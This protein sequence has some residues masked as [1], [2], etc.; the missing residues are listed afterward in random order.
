MGCP[1]G[2]GPMTSSQYFWVC[3]TCGKTVS[4]V[5]PPLPPPLA[6]LLPRLP[7]VL[8]VP[9]DE[10]ARE[11]VPYV[12]LHW[13]RVAAEMLPRFCTAVLLGVL[14]SWN[15]GGEFPK[16]VHR[17]LLDKIEFL[18]SPTV[19]NGVTAAVKDFCRV[20]VGWREWLGDLFA[21][22][23]MLRHAA[24][25]LFEEERWEDLGA[26]LQDGEF[27]RAKVDAGR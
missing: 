22:R 20:A 24:A 7:H 17:E 23:Y 10:Y 25:H 2:H 5:P 19:E 27:L 16:R 15:P 26:L 14:L 4:A 13:L 6:N 18:S 8:A 21:L 11:R 9:I 3:L 1:L 12:K